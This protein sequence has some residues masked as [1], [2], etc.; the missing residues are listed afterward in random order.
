MCEF[1][2]GDLVVHRVTGKVYKIICDA[3]HCRL[4][5]GAVPAY[6][7]QSDFDQV[8]WVREQKEMEDRFVKEGAL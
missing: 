4:E 8:V 6:A 2:T 5:Q 7:Y 3:D 1:K